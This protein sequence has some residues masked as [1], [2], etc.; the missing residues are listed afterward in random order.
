[1]LTRFGGHPEQGI[2]TLNFV[3]RNYSPADP[4]QSADMFGT[5][6]MAALKGKSRKS[7]QTEAVRTV[8]PKLEIEKEM[9][10]V[11]QV[12]WALGKDGVQR[13]MAF[14]DLS[15]HDGANLFKS[16]FEFDVKTNLSK[17]VDS[18]ANTAAKNANLFMDSVPA[19][20]GFMYNGNNKIK[21][22]AQ[23]VHY[24]EHQLNWLRSNAEAS[25]WPSAIN[26][27]TDLP[28][29]YNE[30]NRVPV[31]MFLCDSIDIHTQLTPG[32][33]S[34]ENKG[35]FNHMLVEAT[36]TQGNLPNCTY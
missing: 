19:S 4:R 22:C 33:K 30:S 23:N 7:P 11:I 35:I 9:Q 31:D 24:L 15:A 17:P 14:A 18:D 3:I 8:R 6:A 2:H 13:I 16:K 26:L 5:A 29:D 12:A 32:D 21:F 34:A 27:A 28:K 36:F 25:A 20:W 10:P 1:M